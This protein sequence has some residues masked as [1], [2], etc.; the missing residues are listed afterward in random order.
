MTKK[1]NVLELSIYREY[2]AMFLEIIAKLEDLL[3]KD[4][5]HELLIRET[6]KT[7]ISVF[8]NLNAGYQQFIS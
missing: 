5:K 6:Y 3:S 2:F 7:A 4:T 8:P 1:F